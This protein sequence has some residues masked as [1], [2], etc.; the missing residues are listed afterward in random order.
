MLTSAARLSDERVQLK[1]L[2]TALTLLQSPL[3]PITS[4]ALGPLLGVC[5]GFLAA[6]GFKSTV[7]TTAAA[8]VRQALALLLSYIREGEVEG[9]V[10]RVMSDLCSI[11]A[12]GS[13]GWEKEGGG[14]GGRGRGRRTGG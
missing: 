5:F 3:H 2:Q 9:V 6:K 14:W 10:V 8:T 7:T 4:A 12:G 11:A 1:C 13:K